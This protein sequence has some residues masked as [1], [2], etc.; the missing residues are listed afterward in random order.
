M[1]FDRIVPLR[2]QIAFCTVLLGLCVLLP[3]YARATTTLLAGCE[4]FF[5]TDPGE[6][7]GIFLPSADGAYNEIEE[8]VDLPGVRVPLTLSK[9]M[10]ELFVR[11]RD[12]NGDWGPKRRVTFTVWGITAAEYYFDTDP[13]AENG[14]PVPVLNSQVDTSGIPTTGLVPGV[15]HKLFLRFQDD[16]GRWSAPQMAEFGL[17]PLLLL[18]VI[19]AGTGSGTVISS[20]VPGINC[21]ADCSELYST[22]RKVTL[23]PTAAADSVFSGW[24]GDAD[25][26]D[27]MVTM[28]NAPKTCIATFTGLPQTLTVTKAGTGTGTVSSAPAGITCGAD[29]TEAY[30]YNTVVVLTPT[31]AVGSAFAGWSG[32]PDCADGS[33]TMTAAK[34]CKAT[35]NTAPRQTL[36][37]TKAGTGTGTVTSAPIGI[38]CGA[39]CMEAYLYN[40]V[41]VLT[42]TPTMGSAF[43]GWSGHP[44]CSDGA[45]RMN[46]AKTCTATFTLNLPDFVV[47]DLTLSP[48]FPA[49]NSPFNLRV[50]VKNQGTAAGIVRQLAIW[51]DQPTLQSCN[52]ASDKPVIVDTSLAVGETRAFSIAGLS[53]S[54]GGTKTL[55]AFVDS[56]CATRERDENNNQ[57]TKTYAVGAPDFVVTTIALL[58]VQPIAN[59]TFKA[60]VTI[61][62]QGPLAGDG[63]FLDV[64]GHQ[65]T[66]QACGATGDQYAPV[67]TIAAGASKTLMFSLPAGS[68]GPKTF[69]AF[70]DSWCETREL[71]E[72]NN[73]ATLPYTVVPALL[74]FVVTG[75][76]SPLLSPLPTAP[77][78]PR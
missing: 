23:T 67:G 32:H 74:D 6:G 46:A 14:T 54:T 50:T 76:A 53:V 59:S 30:A 61:K 52:A 38:N 19:K 45:V 4:Y 18:T 43:D 21:G 57:R 20:N 75:I 44:D 71:S 77:S 41:V 68:V 69:R 49:I 60:M 7:S 39:D 35:F 28:M 16:W 11:C 24:S 31:P 55:R 58:P 10:H 34:T 78:L 13:G 37:V 3:G 1:R 65:P 66:T 40:T 2:A 26:S 8:A 56:T 48:A 17:G 51:T 22:G 47:T 64:W 15:V 9:G 73:Q 36:T 33:V 62:N 27:G 25:C 72:S 63:G 5:D 70:I 42:A 12:S 29:C